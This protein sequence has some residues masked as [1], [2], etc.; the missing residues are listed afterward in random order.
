MAEM[1]A[2]C[3]LGNFPVVDLLSF[4]AINMAAGTTNMIGYMERYAAAAMKILEPTRFPFK[5]KSIA[6]A[7]TRL[8]NTAVLLATHEA[9]DRGFNMN[10]P[11]TY[12]RFHAN[13][14]VLRISFVDETSYF[15][16]SST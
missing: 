4:W 6:S 14:S 15:L 7:T 9:I 8:F 11:T 12:T 1:T 3:I 10:A 2:S 16:T 13:A 5:M